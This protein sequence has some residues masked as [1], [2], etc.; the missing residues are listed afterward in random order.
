[1]VPQMGRKSNLS[2]TRKHIPSQIIV[3]VWPIVK[4]SS[5]ARLNDRKAYSKV[6]ENDMREMK[7]SLEGTMH[8]S[9]KE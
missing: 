6:T 5:F 9:P 1:M 4:I 3:V 2:F 8:D 7:A